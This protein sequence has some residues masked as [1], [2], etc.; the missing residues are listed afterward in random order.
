MREIDR[1]KVERGRREAELL[2]RIQD[3]RDD[4]RGLLM[5][6]G[7]LMEELKMGDGSLR[8]IHNTGQGEDVHK[9]FR[10]EGQRI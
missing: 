4:N 3:L 9:Y 1:Q 7:N 10:I 6:K 2:G 5:V 8:A